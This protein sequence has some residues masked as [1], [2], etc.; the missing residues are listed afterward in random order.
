[1]KA[2]VL[3]IAA[4]M[5][6]GQVCLFVLSGHGEKRFSKRG[7]KNL[8]SI[9]LLFRCCDQAYIHERERRDSRLAFKSNYHHEGIEMSQ[10]EGCMQQV[11]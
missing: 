3:V 4:C 11:H 1:M 6:R 5:G 9:S 8:H 7:Y 2:F 10:W